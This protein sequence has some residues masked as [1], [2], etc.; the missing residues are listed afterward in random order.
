MHAPASR[1]SGICK[2][3]PPSC[4]NL[5]PLGSY[6]APL[7]KHYPEFFTTPNH[8][9]SERLRRGQALLLSRPMLYCICC[10]NAREQRQQKN[11]KHLNCLSPPRC[12]T[13]D[14]IDPE[15]SSD[16]WSGDQTKDL[17]KNHLRCLTCTQHHLSLQLVALGNTQLPH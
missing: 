16:F 14:V 12:G 8:F 15:K 2:P 3:L 4:L 6:R 1:I 9:E 7:G 5:Y 13:Q 11:N 17:P 10:G